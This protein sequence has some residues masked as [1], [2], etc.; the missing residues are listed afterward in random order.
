MLDGKTLQKNYEAL[1]IGFEAI[2]CNASGI[3]V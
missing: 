2:K 1:E 3:K